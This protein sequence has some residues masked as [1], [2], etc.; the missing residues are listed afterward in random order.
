MEKT[1][2]GNTKIVSINDIIVSH[3]KGNI[4]VMK[5]TPVSYPRFMLKLKFGT[6]D[7]NGLIK[8]AKVVS[9][10]NPINN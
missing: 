2:I 3:N 4:M 1:E 9:K 8:F 5:V 7:T 6:M 10:Q